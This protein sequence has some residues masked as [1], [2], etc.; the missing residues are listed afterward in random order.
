[1][2]QLFK[3]IK[4]TA[5]MVSVVAGL[6][7]FAGCVTT[8]TNPGSPS[9]T[10]P[11]VTTPDEPPSGLG[12][13]QK[14]DMVSIAFSGVSNPPERFDGRINEKG[15]IEL[16]Y[17]GAVYAVGMSTAELQE[18]IHTNYVPKYFVRLAVVVNSEQRYFTVDRE[19]R[20]P[21]RFVYS[22]KIT[23]LGAIAAANGFTDYADKRHVK[24]IRGS[25]EIHIVDCK[26]AEKDPKLDL[27]VYPYDKIIVD[28]SWY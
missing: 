23:V 3:V 11:V 25:G 17:I 1:M 21:N 27:P 14:G 24:L 2:S 22:G 9:G 19:V 16:P 4:K 7:L 18:N 12:L 20:T 6:A 13:L 28:K 5:W 26:K 8:Q 10:T 15:C